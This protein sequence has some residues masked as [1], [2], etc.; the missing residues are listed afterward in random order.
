V[1]MRSDSWW[2]FAIRFMLWMGTTYRPPSKLRAQPYLQSHGPLPKWTGGE[3]TGLAGRSA[4]GIPQKIT[5]WNSWEFN[6]STCMC[7][8]FIYSSSTYFQFKKGMNTER[9]KFVLPKFAHVLVLE[10]S[11]TT[12]IVLHKPV[13][14]LEHCWELVGWVQPPI[15][16][17]FTIHSPQS[18]PG[19]IKAIK[20]SRL[21]LE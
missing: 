6:L 13:A 3:A 4:E 17:F 19:L 7:F 5:T 1:L 8:S 14:G 18:L 16:P 15:R 2:Q 11:A 9:S 21:Y 10:S 20:I 12:P